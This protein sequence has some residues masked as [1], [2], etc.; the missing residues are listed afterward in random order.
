MLPPFLPEAALKLSFDP[1]FA[2]VCSLVAVTRRFSLDSEEIARF[3]ALLDERTEVFAT[4]RWKEEIDVYK[5]FIDVT[6]YGIC[7][8]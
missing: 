8:L 7:V 2:S 4:I 6:F 5:I 3:Y 1:T